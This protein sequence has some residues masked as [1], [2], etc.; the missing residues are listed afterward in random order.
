MRDELSFRIVHCLFSFQPSYCT[1]STFLP[2]DEAEND[3]NLELKAVK[4]SDSDIFFVEDHKYI[5][6]MRKYLDVSMKST[7]V[8]G[9]IFYFLDFIKL[10]HLDF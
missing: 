9:V 3:N 5:S 6:V 1:R 10:Q 4:R 2:K 7:V 8:C